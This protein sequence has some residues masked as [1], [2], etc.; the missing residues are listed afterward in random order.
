MLEKINPTDRYDIGVFNRN[1]KIIED[2]INEIKEETGT[3]TSQEVYEETRPTDW[4][5]MPMPQDDELYLLFHIPD[6]L[7]SLIAFT[8]TCT[9]S[10]TVETGTMLNGVYVGQTSQVIASGVKYEAELFA[11]DY[12][13]LTSD[14][15]K[16]VMIKVSGTD[17]KTWAP[18]M[19]SKKTLPANFADWNI[20]EISGR[21]PSTTSIS[22]GSNSSVQA[23]SKLMFFSLYG[24]NQII[25]ASY[26]FSNC[27]GLRTI[28]ALDTSNVTGMTYMFQNCY[29]LQT[30]PILDTSKVT[31]MY[32]MFVNCRS[33]QA[34]P[35]LNTSNVINMSYM[36]RYCY[37]LQTIPALDTSKVTNMSYMFSYCCA[38]RTIPILDTSSVTNMEY[39]FQNCYGLQTIPML[40]TSSVTS[41]S[42]MFSGCKA[43]HTVPEMNTEKV[44]NMSYMFSNNDALRTIPQ[45]STAQVTSMA[46]MF[47]NCYA[48]QSILLDP[49]VTGWAGTAISPTNCSLSHQAIIDFFNSLPTITSAKAIT[50]TGNPGASELTDADKAIATQKGWTLTL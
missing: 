6:G 14:G 33:L 19:H 3:K 1:F 27:Y 36:F 38:L 24:T 50:L 17:I 45:F 8:A 2:T 15:F 13:N 21:L 44:T 29:G 49:T 30:I 34:I 40:D 16:Q 4:L 23:L 12:G 7:S 42:Y 46:Y 41:M 32:Y 31:N 47:N 26:M 35:M 37:G 10:Y 39:M 18:Q 48:L 20:V 11:A 9:G 5:S 25:S 43:L 28:P 22:C